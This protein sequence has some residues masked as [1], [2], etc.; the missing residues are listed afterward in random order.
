[1]SVLPICYLCMPTQAYTL[2]KSLHGWCA[3]Q[4]E[5]TRG[6]SQTTIYS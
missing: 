1:M 4:L 6:F 3:G 5:K 2:L